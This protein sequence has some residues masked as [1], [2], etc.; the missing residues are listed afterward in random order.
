ML[1]GFAFSFASVGVRVVQFSFCGFAFCYYCVVFLVLR[2]L[3]DLCVCLFFVVSIL[4]VLRIVF[5]IFWCGLIFDVCAF[6]C[7]SLFSMAFFEVRVV[8]LSCCDFARCSSCVV[9]VF[10]LRVDA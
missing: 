7:C 8:Q 1:H 2:V 10:V 3:H 5:F 4:H 6:N 9:L